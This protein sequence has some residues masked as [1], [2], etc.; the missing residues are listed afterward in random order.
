M[1]ARKLTARQQLT[2]DIIRRHIAA[3]GVPPTRSELSADLGLTNPQASDA[4]LVALS[5]KGWIE[6]HAGVE[7]GIQLLREG[8]PVLDPDELAVVP[9][10]TPM[11]AVEPRG[12]Q[13]LPNE[14]KAEFETEPDCFLRVKGTSM[15]AIG[16]ECDDIVAL[17]YQA[18]ANDGDLIVARVGKEIMLNRFRKDGNGQV[19]LEPESYDAGHE[20]IEIDPARDD[21]AIVG[22]VV[23]AIIRKGPTRH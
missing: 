18:E 5:R 8:T 7:R 20:T 12:G 19:K 23:G 14:L 21:W 13:R 1:R 16:V 15:S 17:R 3:R 11:A 4:H 10:G 22:V 2:L 6:V 9:A